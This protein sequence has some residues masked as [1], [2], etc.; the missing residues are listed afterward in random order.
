MIVS[1][2]I[3]EVTMTKKPMTIEEMANKWPK[4]P[5]FDA[6]KVYFGIYATDKYVGFDLD[7]DSIKEIRAYLDAV[8]ECMNL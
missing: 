5:P 3:A 6:N 7:Q 1:V 4:C 8:E 2:S